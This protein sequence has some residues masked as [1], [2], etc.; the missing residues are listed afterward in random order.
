MCGHT[1]QQKEAVEGRNYLEIKREVIEAHSEHNRKFYQE[2]K[3]NY[4]VANPNRPT[5]TPRARLNA[6]GPNLDKA[7]D[8]YINDQSHY[9]STAAKIRHHMENYEHVNY[10]ALKG[11][12]QKHEKASGKV[13]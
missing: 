2:N 5:E 9:E 4:G 11:R 13:N 3:D 8:D 12:V 1:D 6:R 10:D 7:F